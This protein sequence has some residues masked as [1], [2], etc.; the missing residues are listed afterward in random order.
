MIK[1]TTFTFLMILAQVTLYGQRRNLD[2]YFM[3]KLER[4]NLASVQIA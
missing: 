1:Y 3:K 4:T 2:K